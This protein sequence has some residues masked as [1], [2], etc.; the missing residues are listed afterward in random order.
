VS[1]PAGIIL[2][3][4]A[5]IKRPITAQPL[6][7][8]KGLRHL[9]SKPINAIE[10]IEIKGLK[11]ETPPRLGLE[12]I[13]K[14][15]IIHGRPAIRSYAIDP[16]TMNFEEAT[17]TA[18]AQGTTLYECKEYDFETQTCWGD[19]QKKRN[20]EPGEI[21]TFTLTPEDPIYSRTKRHTRLQLLIH[22][23]KQQRTNKL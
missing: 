10:K 9:L 14:E 2:E 20:L 1:N 17:I 12:D 8:P 11:D 13:N 4:Y 3:N 7:T 18:V 6:H 23:N 19:W 15:V 22:T 21:Y 16:T 5:G